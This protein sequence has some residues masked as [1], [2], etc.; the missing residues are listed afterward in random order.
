MSFENFI[1]K[2]VYRCNF[3]AWNTDNLI[4]YFI[5]YSL[6]YIIKAYLG[7]VITFLSMIALL[8]LFL[9]AE[10]RRSN[11]DLH[12]TCSFCQLKKK[13]QPS[14]TWTWFATFS[15]AA[16]SR[17]R[18][19]ERKMWSTLSVKLGIVDL[20]LIQFKWFK[21]RLL[22]AP[23]LFLLAVVNACKS[24]RLCPKHV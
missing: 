1:K 3:R 5:S 22:M 7:S 10:G 15:I 23:A 13:K 24:R 8:L 4:S 6:I 18:W 2:G 19:Q 14:Q 9:S 20:V 17:L 16:L 12:P 21:W 11:D